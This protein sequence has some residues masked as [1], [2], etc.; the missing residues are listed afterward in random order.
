ML[1]DYYS[2]YF[3]KLLL[4]RT[5][6]RIISKFF[7]THGLPLSIHFDNGP[8][9]VSQHFEDFLSENGI[10]H[11]KTT[12]MWPQANGEVERQNRST[13]IMK[14]IRIAQAEAR[15]WKNELDKCLIMYRNTPH[16]VTGVCP[17]QL[18]FGHKLRT[19][20]PELIDY[21]V[22]DISVRDRDAENKEKGKCMQINVEM[23]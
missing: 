7:V 5:F 3:V 18:L 2:N 13:C 11:Q 14:R 6:Q 12:P 1:V 21:K 22:D 8:Q 4:Q 10:I 19:K 16:S 17:S 9:F 20:L 15:D 23:H